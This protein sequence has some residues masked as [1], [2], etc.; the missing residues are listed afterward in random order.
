M[1]AIA[2]KESESKNRSNWIALGLAISLFVVITLALAAF[3][4]VE[5]WGNYDREALNRASEQRVL[6]QQVAKYILAA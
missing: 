6:S 2:A 3:I 4:H 5:K 1:K